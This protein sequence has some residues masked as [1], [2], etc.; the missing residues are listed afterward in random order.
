MTRTVTLIVLTVDGE[1]AGE[2]AAFDVGTPWWQ[3]VGEVAAAVRERYDLELDVLRLLSAERNR[4][5]GG[6]ITY[7]AQARGPLPA[8]LDLGPVQA[9]LAALVERDEPLR[10]PYARA[11]GASR[12]L[13]WAAEI[14]GP[15][16]AVQQRTW[17][18][19]A[20]WRLEAERG[21]FWLKQ[22]PAWLRCEP[23]ALRWLGE[24]L[25]ELAPQ[26]IAFGEEGREL[27][28]DVPGID[29]YEADLPTRLLIQREAHRFQ[30]AARTDLDRLLADGVQDRRGPALTAWIRSSLQGWDPAPAR[31]LLA[32]LDE[33]MAAVADCGVPDTLGHGDANPGN[34]RGDGDR[35]VFLDWS[36]CYL[37]HPGFDLLGL[38]DGLPA[39]A[40]QAVLEAWSAGWKRE[41]PG[42]DP[43][44]AIELLRP[45]S[46][47][48]SA[49]VYAEF[50]ANIEP[51]EH[52]YHALDVPE[53]LAAA[54]TDF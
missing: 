10:A 1:I 16:T 24:V 46:A 47:L 38:V 3:E 27:L 33:R 42:C 50:L 13:A 29:H 26:V 4:P 20:I 48:R 18:L 21:T 53:Q 30:S 8:G 25:P 45:V 51:N 6:A 37:G 32:S 17:N 49:A 22:L 7:L 54:V 39:D 15:G 23:A 12:S 14:A 35:L 44:R 28:A 40:T 19:S 34:A 31:E 36:E 5:P 52:P 11:G 2:T 9:R 43:I 41:V